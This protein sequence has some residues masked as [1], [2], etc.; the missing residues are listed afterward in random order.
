MRGVH[1]LRGH[2]R[3][4]RGKRARGRVVEYAGMLTINLVNLWNDLWEPR[5]S[6]AV[7]FIAGAIMEM[8]LI[9]KRGLRK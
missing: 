8:T 2:E 1:R 6:I 5:F 3:E 4:L 7:L 9:I